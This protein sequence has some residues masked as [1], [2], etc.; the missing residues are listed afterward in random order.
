MTNDMNLSARP[1][2]G[3]ARLGVSPGSRASTD[4]GP[5]GQ[6][7]NLE[8]LEAFA[9]GTL[10]R[11]GLSDDKRPNAIEVA[12][13]LVGPVYRIK[14]VRMPGDAALMRVDEGW[15][16]YVR[17]GLTRERQRWAVLHEVAEWLLRRETLTAARAEYL[18]EALAA[19]LA[20]P[21]AFAS[22]IVERVGPRYEQLSFDFG[23]DQTGSAL[24]FGEVTDTPLA[25]IGPKR[26]HV[27]GMPEAWAGSEVRLRRLAKAKPPGLVQESL[28]DD[29]QR[30]VLRLG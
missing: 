24:R 7:V 26:C 8:E 29:P 6:T 25:V 3:Q 17:P 21:T 12:E 14:N 30:L 27:R 15:R 2:V 13:S 28:T 11:V 23:F 18:A 22:R 16:I 9:V 1:K 19:R 20:A 10:R 4:R 5:C